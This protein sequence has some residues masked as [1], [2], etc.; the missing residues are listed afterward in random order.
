MFLALLIFAGVIF[1]KMERT[2]FFLVFCPQGLGQCGGGEIQFGR[3]KAKTFFAGGKGFAL[4]R[5]FFAGIWY[6]PRRRVREECAADF[7]RL[8]F[9]SK[10]CFIFRIVF[11]DI[12]LIR[13]LKIPYPVVRMIIWK[14]VFAPLLLFSSYAFFI[15]FCKVG[16]KIDVLMNIFRNGVFWMK[17]KY[18]IYYQNFF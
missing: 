1:S 6:P 4:P 12:S 3:G 8:N 13:P 15:S 16:I 18:S 5:L 9:K 14:I 11:I 10:V 7:L 17:K 2:F